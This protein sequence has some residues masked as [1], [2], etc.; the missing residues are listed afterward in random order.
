[1]LPVKHVGEDKKKPCRGNGER[2]HSV[3]GAYA[4]DEGGKRYSVR[5]SENNTRD[6][7]CW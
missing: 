5:R 2:T 3:S 6:K 7:G 4:G 1:M